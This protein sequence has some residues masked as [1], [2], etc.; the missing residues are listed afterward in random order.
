MTAGVKSGARLVAEDDTEILDEAAQTW[1]APGYPSLP[2]PK[3]V[4]NLEAAL[5][6]VG[7]SA[8]AARVIARASARPDDMRRRLS[9][10]AELRVSGGVMRVVETPVWSAGSFPTRTTH[11]NW[12]AECTRWASTTTRRRISGSYP[13]PSPIRAAP[14]S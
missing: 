3:A 4:E 9:E 5:R 13:I 6:G 14:P 12:A 8:E 10:P 11:A 1:G 7:M 2:R